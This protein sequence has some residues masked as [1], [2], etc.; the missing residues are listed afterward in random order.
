MKIAKNT[1]IPPVTRAGGRSIYP[2]SEMDIGDALVIEDDVTFK[3]ARQA[4]FSYAANEK[5]AGRSVK[6]STRTRVLQNEQTKELY[7][8]EHGGTIWRVDPQA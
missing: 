5:K 4:A 8:S 6:F 7:R 3:R 1:V 2:F